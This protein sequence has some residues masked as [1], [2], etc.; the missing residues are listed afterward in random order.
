[1]AVGFARRGVYGCGPGP[2][3]GVGVAFGCD[4]LGRG[5]C[6]ADAVD[7]GLVELDDEGLGHVVVFVVG[8]EDHFAVGGV[9]GGD[10]FP[11]GLEAGCVCDDVVVVAAVWF[12]VSLMGFW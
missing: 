1:M 10:G 4:V 3:A 5:A 6:C 9:W 2:G 8:V 7:G 11:E 12:K